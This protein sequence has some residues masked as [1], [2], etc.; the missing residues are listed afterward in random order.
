M[1]LLLL[2]VLILFTRISTP[3]VSNAPVVATVANYFLSPTVPA[4][5]YA[6]SFAIPPALFAKLAV[7]DAT[8]ASLTEH[9]A[10]PFDFPA[11][12]GLVP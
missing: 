6:A 9:E 4:A 12:E 8:Q 7:S 11:P 5:T 1:L 10:G 3:S 2:L